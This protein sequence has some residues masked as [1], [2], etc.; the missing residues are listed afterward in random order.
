MKTKIKSLM[1]IL[2]C[3]NSL[4]LITACSDDDNNGGGTEVEIKTLSEDMIKVRNY[5]PKDAIVGHRGTAFWAP[6]STEAAYRWAREAGVDYLEADLQLSKDGII[7][8][9]HDDNI[10]AKTNAMQKFPE[11]NVGTATNP[12]FLVKDFTLAELRQL[13]AGS[14]FNNEDHKNEWRPSYAGLKI[15]TLKDLVKIAEGNRLVY[16]IDGTIS[17]TSDDQWHGNVPGIYAETKEPRLNPG[18]DIEKKL[19]DE[20]DVLGWNVATKPSSDN[21]FYKNSKINVG[22]TNGKVVF[23]TFS[24]ESLTTLNKQ[25]ASK[26]PLCLLLWLD[27]NDPDY[28]MVADTKEEFAKWINYGVDNGAQFMGPSIAEEITE[29]EGSSSTYADLV[30]GWRSELIHSSGMYIHPY[31][32]DKEKTMEKYYQ[33][34]EGMFT[35]IGIESVNFYRSKGKRL[36]APIPENAKDILVRLGY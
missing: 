16:G 17:Y 35:N 6:E 34:C 4:M 29:G 27:P 21:E 13:D 10:H 7:V 3:L 18:Q 12:K 8:I 14:W 31:T 32:F 5:A 1:Y 36:G 20:L 26:V 30:S 24:R 11:K 2:V 28:S 22:N 9:V 19:Y 15:L 25:F 23:Q 33:L